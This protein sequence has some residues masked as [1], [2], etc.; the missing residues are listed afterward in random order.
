MKKRSLIKSN[1]PSSEI[2]EE[3][4]G[5]ISSPMHEYESYQGHRMELIPLLR[6]NQFHLL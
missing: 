1:D 6:C 5:I 2:T 3:E 4:G